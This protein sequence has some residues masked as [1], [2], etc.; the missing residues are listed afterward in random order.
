M[1]DG[2]VKTTAQE[3]TSEQKQIARNN[4]D[5]PNSAYT[6]LTLPQT[7]P[8]YDKSVARSNIGA[9]SDA[10]VV[11][12]VHD[13]GLTDIEK[14]YARENI[15]AADI[16][17]PFFVGEIT[18]Q[19]K[20][21]GE[22][23]KVYFLHMEGPVSGEWLGIA[24]DSVKGGFEF[25]NGDDADEY[26]PIQF[27]QGSDDN[28]GVTLAYLQN[29]V[30]PILITINMAPGKQGWY[31]T[32]N[33]VTYTLVQIFQNVINGAR[34]IAQMRPTGDVLTVLQFSATHIVTEYY[35]G[36][37]DKHMLD[38]FSDGTYQDTTLT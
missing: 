32:K 12:V 30:E 14:R 36:N 4:I 34:C 8:E 28:S 27:A 24:H 5:A 33:D 13:Q 7:M 31:A 15:N 21:D 19:N 35:D 16:E 23:S 38:L 20:P 26:V 22:H 17:Y 18:I 25:T 3:L 9:A 1:G 2:V 37:N 6:V 11:K 10:Q 29:Y